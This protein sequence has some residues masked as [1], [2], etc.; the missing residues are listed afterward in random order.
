LSKERT[1]EKLETPFVDPEPKKSPSPTRRPKTAQAYRAIRKALLT[2]HLYN[3]PMST[4]T[5]TKT[6][7]HGLG[8]SVSFGSKNFQHSK[9]SKKY[10]PLTDFAD[11]LRNSDDPSKFSSLDN[12][13][14]LSH[15]RLVK[16]IERHQIREH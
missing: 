4:L 2:S 9:S 5:L 11:I 7:G 12:Q 14:W 3:R 8:G 6:E 15:L 13:T 1:P 16:P 10:A